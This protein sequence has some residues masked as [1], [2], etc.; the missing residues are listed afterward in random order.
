MKICIIFL[1]SISFIGVSFSDIAYPTLIPDKETTTYPGYL[2]NERDMKYHGIPS[3]YWTLTCSN[4]TMA[5]YFEPE[6]FGINTIFRISKIGFI[7]YITDG[8]AYIYIFLAETKNHPNCTP[9]EF[10]NKKYGSYDGH[11]N[12]SYP[13]YDDLDISGLRW[14]ITKAEIDTQFNKRFWVLYHLKYWPPPYPVSDESTAAK[15]SCI[16]V[17]GT[18]WTTTL[19]GYYPCWCMHVI[20]EYFL[21]SPGI[22]STSFGAVKALFK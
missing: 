18:G 6:K 3:W 8:P 9:P 11:I 19:S 22:E 12:N 5:G 15:N 21:V 16:Y 13:Y 17:P 10:K 2:P 20:V 7:G 4:F 1:L 14:N